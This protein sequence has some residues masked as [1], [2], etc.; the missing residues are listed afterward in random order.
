M[1]NPYLAQL[2][3]PDDAVIA[4]GHGNVCEFNPY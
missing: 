2:F 4:T 1:Y 3:D